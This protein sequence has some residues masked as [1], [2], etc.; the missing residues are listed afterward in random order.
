[1]AESDDRDAR[2]RDRLRMRAGAGGRGPGSAFFG[3]VPATVGVLAVVLALIFFA[4]WIAPA[5]VEE[6]IGERFGLSPARLAAGG[7]GPGGWF[8]AIAPL[9]THAF[10]HA[11]GPHLL[12]NL[13][14]LFVFGTPVA[15]RFD[16]PVRFLLFFAA[17]SAVGGAFFSAFH[18]TD[19]TL[20]I[21]A[22]GGI[23]GLLGG[24]VRFAFHRPNS[25]P[26]SAKGVLPLTDRSVL[27]WSA[28]VIAMNASIAIFGPGAGAGDADIAW[29]AHVGGYLFGL[30]AFPLVDPAR[31]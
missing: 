25:K 16:S 7:A 21:G 22:S 30:F 23:T 24:L 26:A 20:L 28:V 18:L 10:I 9:F 19:S 3:N 1:M 15:R 2:A 13:L 29:Q 5:A 27:I 11:T 12:F 4:L 14:W 8:W 6:G 17:C 31:R